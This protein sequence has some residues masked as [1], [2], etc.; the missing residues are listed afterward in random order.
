[1]HCQQGGE[2]RAC[3]GLLN[4]FG[5]FSGGFEPF[6]GSVCHLSD[7]SECWPCSHVGQTGGGDRSDRSELS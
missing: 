5:R 7:R 4:A 6:L 2:V 3:F 1:M